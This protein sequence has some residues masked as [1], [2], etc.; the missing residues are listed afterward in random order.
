MRCLR[1]RTVGASEKIASFS[2][3][4]PNLA[5]AA[6]LKLEL[7]PIRLSV[8]DRTRSPL[9]GS[10][11]RLEDE[12]SVLRVRARLADIP[13]P[14]ARKFALVTRVPRRPTVLKFRPRRA[15]TIKAGARHHRVTRTSTRLLYHYICLSHSPL[16][17]IQSF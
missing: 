6:V 5:V 9:V 10:V 7:A 15:L 2:W 14:D 11:A 3:R 4:K 13:I 12:T 1:R 17:R 8:A 16:A